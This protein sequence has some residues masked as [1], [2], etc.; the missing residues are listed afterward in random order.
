LPSA[1]RQYPPS[2]GGVTQHRHWPAEVGG[3]YQHCSGLPPV[4]GS[5]STSVGSHRDYTGKLNDPDGTKDSVQAHVRCPLRPCPYPNG[6][7]AGTFTHA[8]SAHTVLGI[9]VQRVPRSGSSAVESPAPAA[10]AA[11]LGE[12]GRDATAPRC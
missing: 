4:G 8:S 12:R 7:G 10:R 5:A 9:D 2:H 3:A 1:L 11:W 6:H